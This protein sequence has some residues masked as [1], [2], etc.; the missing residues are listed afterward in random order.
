MAEPSGPDLPEEVLHQLQRCD[1]F[2][3]L[4]MA[5]RA[6]AQWEQIA[7]ADRSHPVAQ[8]LLMRLLVTE[9]NWTAARDLAVRFHAQAPGEAG[10]WIQ[11]AYTT[12]RADTIAAA[13]T[14]LWEAHRR[15]PKESVIVYNLACYACQT[16]RIDEARELL[17]TSARLDPKAL[18]LACEDDDLRP[19]WPELPGP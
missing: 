9:K 16:G 14:I 18:D 5:T 3:D 2:L 4:K 12:R 8:P 13:E 10:T 19:L 15:F 11:L 7:E 6:R 1:G 17:Q